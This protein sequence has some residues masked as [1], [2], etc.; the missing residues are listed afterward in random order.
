M[1]LKN[2]FLAK[3]MIL[4]NSLIVNLSTIIDVYYICRHGK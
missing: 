4:Y 3:L 2:V 1:S